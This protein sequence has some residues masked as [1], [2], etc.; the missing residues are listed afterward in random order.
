MTDKS[1][2]EVKLHE[3]SENKY[4]FTMPN[5]DVSIDVEF[6]AVLEQPSTILPYTD[7]FVSDPSYEAVKY[8]YARATR[9][10]AQML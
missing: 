3:Q 5:C 10:S 2:K 9:R 4:T 1:G 8:V 6:A 7:V